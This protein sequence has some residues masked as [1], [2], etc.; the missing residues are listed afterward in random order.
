MLPYRTVLIIKPPFSILKFFSKRQN[1][2]Q[3]FAEKFVVF[4]SHDTYYYSSTIQ[5]QN[6]YKNK[7]ILYLFK[8][9]LKF[10][11]CDVKE[12]YYKHL[13]YA[14]YTIYQSITIFDN[15]QATINV[16]CEQAAGDQ[17]T[18]MDQRYLLPTYVPLLILLLSRFV[19]TIYTYIIVILCECRVE[20][21]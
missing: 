6:G 13:F 10:F 16:S 9:K 12:I 3:K 4:V 19:Y 15:R 18:V 8:K 11:S 17:T 20:V 14:Q 21:I 1:S 7:N 5:F 2:K